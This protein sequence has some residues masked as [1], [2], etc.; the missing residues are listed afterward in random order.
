M[1]KPQTFD[2][3]LFIGQSYINNDGAQLYLIFQPIYKTI[4]TF[5]DLPDIISEWECKGLSNEKIKPPFTAIKS[6]SPKLVWMN[7]S[8]IRQRF[9]GSCLGQEFATFT[10]NGV[11]NL[12]IVYE[13]D[14]WSQD[15]NAKFTLKDCL[16][17]AVKLTKNAD[18]NKYSYSGCGI[19]FDSRSLFSI[20]NF[21]WGK[22]AIIV[23]VDSSSVHAN[24]ENK[25]I[26]ILGKGQKKG[27]SNTSLTAE[28]EYFIR[29][30]RSE[31]KF[32]F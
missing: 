32:C 21:D 14:R 24:N 1:K 3:S 4:T 19:G 8:E 13:L 22:N 5:Y 9:A 28:A 26:L 11:V 25:D 7:N 12:F 20:P 27:L 29:F 15:L 18:S 10:P 17:G 2:S 23:G 30:S 31:R 6:L 16:F